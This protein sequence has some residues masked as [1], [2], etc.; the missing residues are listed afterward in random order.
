MDSPNRDSNAPIVADTYL[1]NLHQNP[2]LASKINLAKPITVEISQ[3]DCRKGRIF[4]KAETGE[5]VGIVKSRDWL[6][7][8][9][10]VM[11]TQSQ[12][13]VIIQLQQQQ[14][15]A[16]RFDPLAHN[17]AVHLVYLGHVLGN[18]HW[19][20]TVQG[21]ILYVEL[22]TDAEIV[23]STVLEIV[24]MHDIEGLSLCVETRNAEQFISFEQQQDRHS[25]AHHHPH[26][27]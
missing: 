7:K 8:D 12:Q 26:Q 23:E 16:I 22:V 14:V 9:G 15:V 24:K 2:T 5:S 18:H 21:H 4:V 10:D 11:A 25:H 6:L 19:P 20:I 13:R 1:G 3:Q 17:H 27:T